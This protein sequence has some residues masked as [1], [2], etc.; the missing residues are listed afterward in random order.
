MW[1]RLYLEELLKGGV[2][3]GQTAVLVARV[4]WLLLA[5]EMPVKMFKKKKTQHLATY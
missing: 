3:E 1:K 4:L 2:G 5:E